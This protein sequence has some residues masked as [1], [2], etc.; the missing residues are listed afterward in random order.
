MRLP[1]L[2]VLVLLAGVVL[3]AG[4]AT[5]GGASAA[6]A[7]GSGWLPATTLFSATA[8]GVGAPAVALDGHRRATAVWPDASEHVLMESDWTEAGGWTQARTL[9]ALGTD[10][11]SAPLL[12]VDAG[13]DALMAWMAGQQLRASYRTAGGEWQQP[14]TLSRPG[15][16]AGS[17]Q[18]AIDDRGRSLVLWTSSRPSSSALYGYAFR[19]EVVSRT[20]TGVWAKPKIICAC[21]NVAALAMNASGHALV[22]WSPKAGLWART[23]SPSG[24]WSAAQRISPFGTGLVYMP[25]ALNSRGGAVVAWL[26]P[27]PGEGRLDVAI[28]GARGRFGRP[29][30]IGDDPYWGFVLALAPTGEATVVWENSAGC[31]F[32][33]SRLPGASSFSSQQS[34]GCGSYGETVPEALSMDAR[35]NALAL[36]LKADNVYATGHIHLQAA[37]RPAGGS[38][39]TGTDIADMGLDSYKHS[40]CSGDAQLAVTPDG[41]LA[42]A[43]WLARPHEPGTCTQVQATTLTR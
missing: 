41:T 17:P 14:T 39:D 7:R 3:R 10:V 36:W 29:Q 12:A 38:F 37:Q 43:V 27:G 16:S 21:E 15:E 42:L 23:R 18:I 32:S 20:R 13:G 1:G 2:L 24:R 25:L 11:S 5:G 33:M 22:V 19:L 26:G 30:P 34:L 9:T 35:G 40:A 8:G 28:R 4:A 31:G 6:V